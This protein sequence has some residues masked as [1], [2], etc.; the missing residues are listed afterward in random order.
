M[1]I[2]DRHNNVLRI[3]DKF[4]NIHFLRRNDHVTIG[5]DI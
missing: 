1:E 3:S 2:D 5:S 4:N